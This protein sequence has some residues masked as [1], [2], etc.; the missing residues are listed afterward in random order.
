MG[1]RPHDQ[2]AARGA[3]VLRRGALALVVTTILAAL[4]NGC[5]ADDISPEA[6]LAEAAT[7]TTD[8]GTSRVS[9]SGSLKF[10]E[11][12][13]V[14]FSGDGVFVYDDLTGRFTYD[15]SEFPEAAGLPK[16]DGWV[17]EVV[18]G[19]DRFYLRLPVL[20]QDLPE[21]K[22][23]IEIELETV[24]GLTPNELA[25]IGG[26][27]DPAQLL[28]FLRGASGE[29][30]TVGREPV[31]GVDTTHYRA[32]VDLARVIEK[33]PE[34][35][36]AT[37]RDQ[38]RRRDE[39]GLGTT[40][41]MEVWIDGEG[42]A[43]RIRQTDAEGDITMDLYDFGLQVDVQLPPSDQVMTEDELDRLIEESE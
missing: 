17:G 34:T 31:R 38:L 32:T 7:K 40:F 4:G 37:L 30:E 28:Q 13:P 27:S 23:W 8:A 33:A 26:A 3:E 42:L 24:S 10:P 29:V 20:T 11:I 22:P 43:R 19:E 25:G 15:L 14:G 5:G 35:A 18:M 36:R 21:A 16:T 1:T 41:D 6:A 2:M 39:A 12:D 9:F